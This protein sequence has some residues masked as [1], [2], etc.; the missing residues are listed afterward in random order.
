MRGHKFLTPDE[1]A[2]DTRHSTE[3]VYAKLRSGGIPGF[4][5]GGSWRIP[6]KEYEEWIRARPRQSEYTTN[7]ITIDPGE[8]D[9][10]VKE[11]GEG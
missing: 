2:E 1:V 5:I 9:S 3:W 6:R 7:E 4:K 8:L 11:G 10:T